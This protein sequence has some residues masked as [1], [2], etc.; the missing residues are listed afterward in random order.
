MKTATDRITRA[1]N[2]A[3]C[4]LGVA[5]ALSPAI[6]AG[7]ADPGGDIYPKVAVVDGKFAVTFTANIHDEHH[8]SHMSVWRMIFNTD[9][10]VFAPRPTIPSA[11]VIPASP[12]PA[13]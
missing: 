1:W 10:T 5:A 4:F 3:G 8:D 9:G 2:R 6:A 7:N 11:A 13:P 12:A